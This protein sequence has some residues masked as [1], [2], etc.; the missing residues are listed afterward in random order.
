MLLRTVLLLALVAIG[1]ASN[2][3]FGVYG[4]RQVS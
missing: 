1:A 3:D 4:L 2:S